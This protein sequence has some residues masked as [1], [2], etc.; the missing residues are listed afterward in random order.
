MSLLSG[1]FRRQG[2]VFVPCLPLV[3]E[4]VVLE[5]GTNPFG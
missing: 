3:G 4:F 5:I 2:R 1:S